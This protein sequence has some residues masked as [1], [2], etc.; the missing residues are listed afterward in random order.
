MGSNRRDL[1]IRILELFPRRESKPK[2]LEAALAWVKLSETLQAHE[3][4]ED[5][6]EAD[7]ESLR[8]PYKALSYAWGLKS[9]FTHDILLNGC[10][11]KITPTLAEALFHLQHESKS[12]HLWVDQ[13]CI[14]QQDACEKSEQVK[15]M[16]LI[17]KGSVE[18][19]VWLGPTAERSEEVFKLLNQLGSFAEEHE[20][21][22]Y[23]T[24]ARI[25]EL[26]NIVAKIN[27]EDETTKMYHDFCN[28]IARRF[29]EDMLKALLALFQRSWFTR[30]WV[31][32]EFALPKKVTLVCGSDRIDA[33]TLFVVSTLFV[34]IVA[35]EINRIS[36]EDQNMQSLLEYIIHMGNLQPFYSSRQKHRP[37]EE[38]TTSQETLYRILQR[39]HLN[40]HLEA[41]R[42]CDMIYG[43]F[44]LL[45]GVEA[46]QI[47]IKY[48]SDG[49]VKLETVTAYIDAARHIITSSDF[50]TP[51]LLTFVQYPKK[52]PELPSWVPD[53]RAPIQPSFAWCPDEESKPLFRTSDGKPLEIYQTD[54]QAQLA[55]LGYKVD[56]VEEV[57]GPWFGSTR[58]KLSSNNDPLEAYKSLLSQIRLLLLLSKHKGNP[59]YPNDERREEAVWRIPIGDI[60]QDGNAS[61]IRATQSCKLRYD[62]YI[63]RGELLTESIRLLGE[64]SDEYKRR[65]AEIEAMKQSDAVALDKATGGGEAYHVRMLQMKDKRPFISDLGYVGMG[66]FHMKP[67]DMVVVLTGA[68]VPFI[69]RPID[70]ERFKL[71][72]EC[73]CDG[74]MDGEIVGQRKPEKIV[75]I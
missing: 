8:K 22:L 71:L 36:K 56:V 41:T 51:D 10:T 70:G 21:I 14:N 27:P 30:I 24:R 25:Q 29:T 66:P 17:Y 52:D 26:Q 62:H 18:T 6:S 31:V 46:S 68:S 73:Y 35:R 3:M 45:S 37:R 65:E 7:S 9:E 53:W 19:L 75:L 11:F 69:V 72:G 33:E 1:K 42:G 57:G 16:D 59:I 74:I 55:L 28:G 34:A 15:C 50:G 67:G 64:D 58:A 40:Q 61:P 54:D 49:D 43:L 63:A 4:Q 39:L 13:I 44:G 47:Q 12:L 60:D 20:V 2:S 48:R 32:Q 5:D 38:G 23:F